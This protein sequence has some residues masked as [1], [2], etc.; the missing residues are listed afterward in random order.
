MNFLCACLFLLQFGLFWS[1]VQD[2]L[3]YFRE[4]KVATL[5]SSRLRSRTENNSLY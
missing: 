5:Y 3:I 1:F 4:T 2:H